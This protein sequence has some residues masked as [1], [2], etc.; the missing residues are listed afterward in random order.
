MKYKIRS[1]DPEWFEKQSNTI[2]RLKK[3][4]APKLVIEY[5]EMMRDWTP[6]T[7][8][9]Y[10]IQEDLVRKEWIKN[11]PMRQE[12]VVELYR[13]FDI[14]KENTSYEFDRQFF[15]Y[16]G[17]FFHFLMGLCVVGVGDVE[18]DWMDSEYLK[19][20]M[21]LEEFNNGLYDDL[22]LG[23]QRQI[24]VDDDKLMEI[25]EDD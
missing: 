19:P 21:T 16:T 14:M 4:G 20:A 9:T 10:Y 22:L 7:E 17:S 11:N 15:G 6:D 2:E 3:M 5:Y 8:L 1:S 25:P 12:V 23:L 24:L 18:R 13:R